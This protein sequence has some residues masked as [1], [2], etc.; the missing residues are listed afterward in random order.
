MNRKKWIVVLV[1]AFLLTAIGAG[2]AIGMTNIKKTSDEFTIKPGQLIDIK[3]EENPSTGYSWS[4]SISNNDVVEV[5]RDY[6]AEGL[7]IIGGGGEHIWKIKGLEKGVATLTFSYSRS[8]EENR[9]IEEKT[10]TIRVK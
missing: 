6:F 7:P 2:V 10:F 5:A 9:T 3:L 4:V 8:W 1:I